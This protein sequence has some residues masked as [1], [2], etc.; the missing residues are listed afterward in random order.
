MQGEGESEKQGE[1]G[2]ERSEKGDP[3]GSKMDIGACSRKTD[4]DAQYE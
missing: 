4:R 2:Y 3:T 1:T